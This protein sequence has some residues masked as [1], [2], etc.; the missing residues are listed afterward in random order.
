MT[1]DSDYRVPCI[2]R[3]SAEALR[4]W[5][6]RRAFMALCLA[7]QRADERMCQTLI[8]AGLTPLCVALNVLLNTDFEC[9]SLSTELLR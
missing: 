7:T 1:P 8:Q 6:A 2:E 5:F 3:F 4:E 9:W